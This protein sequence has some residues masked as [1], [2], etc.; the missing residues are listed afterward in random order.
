M[1]G[2][3]R[4]VKSDIPLGMSWHRLSKVEIHLHALWTV[5]A[6]LAICMCGMRVESVQK[7]THQPGVAG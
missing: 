7:L 1:V 2:S 4:E 6:L 5:A 3:C